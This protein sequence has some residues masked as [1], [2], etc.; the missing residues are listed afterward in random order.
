LAIEWYL[1]STAA[2]HECQRHNHFRWIEYNDFR[3]IEE[4]GKGGFSVVYKTSYKTYFGMDEEVAIKIIKD[5]HNNKK[6]F[7]NE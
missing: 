5:S 2:G 6:L 4:V 3:N 7:L 1:E